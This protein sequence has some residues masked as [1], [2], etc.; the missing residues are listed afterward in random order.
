[1]SNKNYYEVMIDHSSFSTAKWAIVSYPKDKCI[2]NGKHISDQELAQKL[3]AILSK[4]TGLSKLVIHSVTLLGDDV[5]LIDNK[6][7]DEDTQ[8]ST[9]SEKN[10]VVIEF[11]D[12]SGPCRTTPAPLVLCKRD[13]LK[14]SSIKDAHDSLVSM[15]SKKQLCYKE[16]RLVLI[17][18]NVVYSSLMSSTTHWSDIIDYL[19]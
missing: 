4:E 6:A 7:S 15:N 17:N 9:S 14:F 2:K 5:I 3:L 18:G 12:C 16:P 10:T 13:K 8:N 1:M 11:L 19:A